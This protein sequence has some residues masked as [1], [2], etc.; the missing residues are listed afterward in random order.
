MGYLGGLMRYYLGYSHIYII[1]II[2]IKSLIGKDLPHL[3]L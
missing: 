3:A 2:I 1:I